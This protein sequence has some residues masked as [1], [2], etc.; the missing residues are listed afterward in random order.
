[1]AALTLTLLALVG[2]SCSQASDCSY[3]ALLN[4][5]KLDETNSGLQIERPVKNWNTTTEVQLEITLGGILDVNEKLQTV[6]I[7]IYVEMH[8]TNEYLTWN[9]S[10][11]C[12]INLL[13]IPVSMI[14]VPDIIIQEDASDSTNSQEDPLVSVFPN[15]T[16]GI[17]NR[18]QLTYI[19]KFNLFRF[20]FD[21][22]TCNITFSSLTYDESL[23]KLVKSTDDSILTK[24]SGLNM[25][26]EGEWK[27][28]NI[29]SIS[30]TS[31]AQRS[32][33]VYQ[34]SLE[35]KPFLYVVNLIL[36]LLFLLVL[37]LASFFVSQSSGEK[38]GFQVTILLSVFVL[39]LILKDIL[40]STEESLP[41]M[42][43]YCVSVFTLVWINV[44]E[45]MLI[46]P[47][48]D[49]ACCV[50]EERQH[51]EVVK[52]KEQEAD[53]RNESAGV[54]GTD[55]PEETNS[56]LDLPGDGRQLKF[57]MDRTKPGQKTPETKK[58]S[59]RLRW[60]RIFD[61]VF[62]I[63]YFATVVFSQVFLF[64]LWKFY[65]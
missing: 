2:V 41:L 50:G 17:V 40:P 11:F 44:L 12:G 45:T 63:L 54:S 55:Q 30:Y 16:V 22:Q 26:T 23:L 24:L 9:S 21:T 4:H 7:H 61:S 56:P 36:P 39:L 37:D 20:P 6:T 60:V 53:N 64:S 27:L 13:T 10:E 25:L 18:L 42:A 19:C 8:W 65:V 15:G 51:A 14:W 31:F 33:L 52:V 46:S 29:K 5:L 49:I 62:F 34:I 32:E 48:K 59:N 3:S 38:L 57:I 28:V 1:M 58:K 35:R 43:I 47:L